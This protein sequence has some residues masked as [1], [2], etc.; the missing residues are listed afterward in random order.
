MSGPKVVGVMLLVAMLAVWSVRAFVL[1]GPGSPDRAVA[2]S[3]T[4]PGPVP[5]GAMPRSSYTAARP[6]AVVAAGDVAGVPVGYPPSSSGA[7]TAAVNW[8]ASFPII[9]RMGPIRLNDTIG[10]LLS[11][12]QAALGTEEV[13]TDYFRLVAELG[14]DL[15][16]R[17]WIESPLQVDVVEATTTSATVAVWSVLVTGDPESGPVEALWRTHRVALVWEDDDWRIDGVTITEG[18]TPIGNEVAL[19][20]PPADFIVVDQWG[21]AVFADS[22]PF[23]VGD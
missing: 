19:P 1:G 12:Q 22:A 4:A 2:T 7:A 14:P 3:A 23:E 17:V 5:R 21:P 9:V 6:D 8:V 15:A 16:D 10:Q 13:V 18:P 11:Q 20:S